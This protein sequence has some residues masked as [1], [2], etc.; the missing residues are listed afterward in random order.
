MEHQHGDQTDLSPENIGQQEHTF[1]DSFGGS[2]RSYDERQIKTIA[3][4]ALE[5]E[6]QELA[7]QGLKSTD[8]QYNK[9]DEIA[10]F[11]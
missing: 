7:E 3:K 5:R 1:Q 4:I 10:Q 6:Q 2:P 9:A 11:Y 8:E